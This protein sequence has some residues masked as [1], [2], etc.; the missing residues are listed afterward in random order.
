MD[1]KKRVINERIC[2]YSYIRQS[3]KGDKIKYERR[4]ET[5]ERD[6]TQ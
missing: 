2:D 1:V 4:K 3:E 6:K 5:T